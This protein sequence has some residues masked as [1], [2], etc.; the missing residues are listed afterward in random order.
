MQKQVVENGQCVFSKIRPFIA[1]E[2][3]ALMEKNEQKGR[4][5]MNEVLISN[6]TMMPKWSPLTMRNQE[7]EADDDGQESADIG[8]ISILWKVRCENV[9]SHHPPIV[10]LG[11]P[12][13]IPLNMY[14]FV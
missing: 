5:C 2:V 4:V 8:C 14:P 3:C 10:T 1:S 9:K 7:E 6:L 13:M 12:C 11:H